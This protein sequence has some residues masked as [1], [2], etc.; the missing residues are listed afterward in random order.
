MRLI[1]FRKNLRDIHAFSSRKYSDLGHAFNRNMKIM[2][3]HE[4]KWSGSLVVRWQLTGQAYLDRSLEKP[5]YVI[6]KLHLFLDLRLLLYYT[7]SRAKLYIFHLYIVAF[8]FISSYV[9]SLFSCQWRLLLSANN[10][11]KQFVPR[12]VPT[13]CRS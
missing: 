1:N 3:I 10:L 7:S 6:V 4:F 2:S 9:S 8:I 12:S 13:K 11:C 5:F